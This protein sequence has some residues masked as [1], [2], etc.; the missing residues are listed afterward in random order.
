MADASAQGLIEIVPLEGDYPT[1]SLTGGGL[2]Y[3]GVTFP[4]EQRGKTTW[5]PGN[6]VAT[7]TV[8]GPIRPPTTMTG[9][10]M[11]FD[12][13]EGGARALVLQF[14]ELIDR[15]IPVE[16]RWGGRSLSTGEDPA[17]TQRGY[18][19]KFEPKYQRSQDI[20]WSITF[21]WRGDVLQTQPPSFALGGIVKQDSFSELA[22]QLAT[23]QEAT[24]SWIDIAWSAIATGTNEMLAVSDALDEVQNAIFQATYVA[25]GA[26]DMLQT[27][28][29]LP[30]AVADRIRGMCD[31]VIMAC[32]NARAALQAACGLFSGVIAA[33][34]SGQVDQAVA[35]AFQVQAARAKLAIFP[36]DDPMVRLDGQTTQFDLISTWDAMAAQASQTA[37][38][39][40]AQQVPDIIA[41]VRPPAGSDL[42]DLAITYY[43]NPDLWILIADFN[44]LDSSE[45]PATSTG[46]SDMGAPPIYIPAQAD[47]ATMLSEVWGDTPTAGATQ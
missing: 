23:T 15:A 38:A 36:T 8:T 9:R 20:E 30:S 14:D 19:K 42:R 18:I 6:P 32:A 4:R 3:K 10:W 45:V 17:I 31:L 35:Q 1:I 40:A 13:G 37:A 25:N 47:Y 33:Q 39:I 46:P 29:Q 24:Q 28:A 5:Y 41:V 43:G 7:Q 34:Q 22:D 21:E 26:S 27:A 16:V 11:D 2:P 12:L 44:D